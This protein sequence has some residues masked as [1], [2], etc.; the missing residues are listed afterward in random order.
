MMSG[1][2]RLARRLEAVGVSPTLAVMMEAKAL[3]E[4]GV[5][6]IDFGPGEPD[7]DTPANIKQA[8]VA[9]LANN[10]THYT[11]TGGILDLRR[12]IAARYGNGSGGA[13][14]PEEVITG[15]GG[16]N[17]LFLISMAL[18]EPGDR[19]GIFAPY[20]VSF[21]EQVRLCGAEP[22]FT[23]AREDDGFVPRARDLEA[24]RGL[25]AIIVNSPCNPSGA[26]FPPEE[27]ERLAAFAARAGCWLISD[28]TYDTFHYGPGKFASFAAQ[29][30]RLRERLILVN[31]LS[32]TYAM[33]GWRVGYA[34]GPRPLIDALRKIQSHDATHTSSIS[35]AAAVE[36]LRGPQD[37]VAAMR[38][39]YRRRRD[40]LVQS[41]NRIRGITCMLPPGSF[42]VFPNVTEA[43][44][45][46]GC[47]TSIDF[48]RRLMAE[49]GVATVPGEAFGMPGFVRLSYALGLDRIR[50]GVERLQALL[51]PRE[52]R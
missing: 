35:Q 1:D 29:H 11:D 37:S 12:A 33:T 43:M 25:K 7:F 16:K 18:L 40:E 20:W 36:A 4:R 27:V 49:I 26:V 51:G 46:L 19:V 6:V 23:A 32:K 9:A 5:D 30:D 10:Q 50:A 31:S 3:R 22:V 38:E 17:V 44:A 45:A 14:G 24:H 34:L 42:Y 2:W 21:P 41:L 28:E 47:A 52:A 48:G 13:W 15:C 8:A 39:E